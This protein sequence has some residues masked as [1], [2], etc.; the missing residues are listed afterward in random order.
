VNMNDDE[1][2][3]INKEVTLSTNVNQNL[4]YAQLKLLRIL[5]AHLATEVQ[6]EIN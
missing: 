1:K 4:T 3:E 5:S 2:V 6:K